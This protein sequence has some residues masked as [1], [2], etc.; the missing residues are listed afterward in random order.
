MDSNKKH[1]ISCSCFPFTLF[2]T[3]KFRRPPGPAPGV[4]VRNGSDEE[5][6]AVSRVPDG[7]DIDEKSENF[8]TSFLESCQDSESEIEVEVKA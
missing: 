7:F 6:A 1:K 2:K 4:W 3:S 8:I 5:K